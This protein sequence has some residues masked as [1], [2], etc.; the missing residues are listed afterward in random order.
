L[1]TLFDAD[2]CGF[3]E[4]SFRSL[5]YFSM[6]MK[7]RSG[8]NPGILVPPLRHLLPRG[9]L[10]NELRFLGTVQYD[11]AYIHLKIGWRFPP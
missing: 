9:T 11:A 8:A 2:I 5:L 3:T 6:K 4:L 7:L 10:Q 1:D